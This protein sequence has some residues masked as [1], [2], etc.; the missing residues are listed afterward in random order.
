MFALHF[1]FL[2]ADDSR[3]MR[4]RQSGFT[5]LELLVVIIIIAIIVSMTFIAIGHVREQ[6]RSTQCKNNVRQLALGFRMYADAHGGRF[7]DGTHEPWFVSV[8][9]MIEPA[10]SIFRCP[11]DPLLSEMSYNWRDDATVTPEASLAGKKI[12][13]VANNGLVLVFDQQA[14]WHTAGF[15]NTSL[16]NA[17]TLSMEDLDFEE[18]LLYDVQSGNYSFLND[19]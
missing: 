13:F 8:A 7:P 4:P 2:L 11:A 5:L 14:G 1:Q 12:D 9:S 16:V 3:T 19:L 6:A 10:P 17:A 15:I 18:N